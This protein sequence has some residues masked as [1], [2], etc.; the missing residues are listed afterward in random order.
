MYDA[1]TRVDWDLYKREDRTIMAKRTLA[2]EC[3]RAD[4]WMYVRSVAALGCVCACSDLLTSTY[5]GG[6]CTRCYGSTKLSQNVHVLT[7]RHWAPLFSTPD[8]AVCERGS[9]ACHSHVQ[10][11]RKQQACVYSK[12]AP[13]LHAFSRK[14][15]PF[16]IAFRTIHHETSTTH[17]AHTQARRAKIC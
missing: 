1:S 6:L 9:A 10:P 15:T 14:S 5:F 3:V 2:Y 4:A 12:A 11:G 17:R 7:C 13:L 8:L 16:C